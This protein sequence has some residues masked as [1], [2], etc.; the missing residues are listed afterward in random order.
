RAIVADIDEHPQRLHER[1]P[2]SAHPATV[3]VSGEGGADEEDR[4]R[5]VED[6]VDEDAPGGADS[7]QQSGADD[8]TEED[9]EAAERRMET[10]RARQLLPIDEAMEH[11]LL[12]RAP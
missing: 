11:H 10:D 3:Q 8:R 7:E 9:A 6:D 5:Q 1:R 12:G 4:Q 2:R